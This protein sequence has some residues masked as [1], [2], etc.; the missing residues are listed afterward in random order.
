MQVRRREYW[1]VSGEVSNRA[2]EKIPQRD[3]PLL[4]RYLYN[5]YVNSIIIGYYD[6]F[7]CIYVFSCCNGLFLGRNGQPGLGS[8]GRSSEGEE[9]NIRIL[10]ISKQLYCISYFIQKK[11]A[12]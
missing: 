1:R 11:N 9:K 7:Y 6:I 10:L 12:K 4:K 3:V 2:R 5:L 8:T